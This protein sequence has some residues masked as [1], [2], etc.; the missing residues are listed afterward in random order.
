MNDIARLPAEIIELPNSGHVTP[1]R[2]PN[3]WRAAKAPGERFTYLQ[4]RLMA[5]MGMAADTLDVVRV[6]SVATARDV[7][8]PE[9]Q[10]APIFGI[11][12]PVLETYPNGWRLVFGPRGDRRM[13][14]ESG[15]LDLPGM[16]LFALAD[17]VMR[18]EINALS[19]KQPWPHHI[20]HDGKDIE[21]R[22][23]P[24]RG[25][26]WVIVH[27]GKNPDDAELCAKLGAPRGG[28]VGMMRITDCVE[29]S[30]S[31]WFV[32]RYGFVIGEQFPLPLIPCKGKLGFFGLDADV[33]LQVAV[34]IQAA[35]IATALPAEPPASP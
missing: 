22:D 16:S 30:P 13:V 5:D 35:A 34:A 19:I 14:H 1:S 7:W 15:K 27:A 28:V 10:E 32:G 9:G 24:T 12:C 26:G 2:E 4:A 8:I 33:N 23:W 17:R 3:P 21:N 20:F 11:T 29:Q 6:Y 18:G 25:R 31:R